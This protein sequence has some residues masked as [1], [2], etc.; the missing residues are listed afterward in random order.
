MGEPGEDSDEKDPAV[1]ASVSRSQLVHSRPALRLRYP[2]T[3]DGT[4]SAHR[5]AARSRILELETV[6][7]FCVNNIMTH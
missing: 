7:L 3:D 2:K 4:G 6:C 5:L 1:R